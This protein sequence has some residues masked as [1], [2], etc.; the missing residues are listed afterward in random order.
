MTSGTLAILFGLLSALL[1]GTGDFIGGFSS[2]RTNAFIVVVI[3]QIFGLI[4]ITGLAILYAEPLPSFND[5][6]FSGLAGF[7][8]AFGIIA[9]YKGLSSSNMGFVAPVSAIVTVILPI[10]VSSIFEGLPQFQQIIGSILA[11]ISIWFITIT[12][13]REKSDYKEL[14][15]PLLAGLGFAGFFILIDQVT[16]GTVWW[17]LV[18]VRIVSITTVAAIVLIGGKIETPK[19]NQV[20]LIAFAGI[21]D[22]G[23]NFFFILSTQQGRLDIAAL[24]SSLYTGVTVILAW[25]ILKENITKKQWIAITGAIVSVILIS[26]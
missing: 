8:G 25:L 26:I 1:W 5:V 18:T 24:L 3:S 21:F 23:G 20:P 11:L 10:I 22:I 19:R 4:V 15:Q 9:L 17:P 2:K 13:D 16:E 14:G 12:S 7:C 6:F